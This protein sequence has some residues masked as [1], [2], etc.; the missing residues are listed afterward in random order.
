M[1]SLKIPL[2]T[3]APE[4]NLKGID[5]KIHSLRNYTDYEVLV[6][7]FT[8]NHCPYAQAIW[9]RLTALH[10]KYTLFTKTEN[11]DWNKIGVQK[12]QFI[13]INPNF[14][15]AYPDDS[16]EKMKE[17][18]EKLN[19]HFP[20]LQDTTQNVAR[21]YQA[22]CTPDIFVYDRDRKLVYH[23]RV[24]DNWKEPEKVSRYE[25]D[26]AITALLEKRQPVEK[27]YPSMGCSIK[28]NNNG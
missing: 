21:A 11:A 15:P 2:G 20:Y 19:L 14:N 9:P 8:C 23:G 17:Y 5:G 16:F 13:A 1:E 4:F 22:Q 24:D 27:Q 28:Y 18:A 26:E 10:E 12:V 25:L 3:P 6:I 7:V